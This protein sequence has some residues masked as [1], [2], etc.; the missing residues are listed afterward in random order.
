[1]QE[2]APFGRPP[3]KSSLIADPIEGVGL[4]YG[5]GSK[6]IIPTANLLQYFWTRALDSECSVCGQ[7]FE[8]GDPHIRTVAIDRERPQWIR[9]FDRHLLCLK[10]KE[11]VFIPI[12]HVWHDSVAVAHLQQR[13]DP[14]AA[15][16]L[17]QVLTKILPNVSTSF[18]QLSPQVELWHDYLSIPQWQKDT[19]HAL[20]VMLPEIFRTAPLCLI[21]LDDVPFDVVKAALTQNAPTHV[22]DDYA[23]MST[24]FRARWFERMW[25]S[26][27]YAYC[28][29]AFIYTEDHIIVWDS[30]TE[31]VVS[32]TKLFHA[33]QYKLRTYIDTLGMDK[34]SKAFKGLP[35]PLLGPLADMRRNVW[36]NQG[37]LSFAE[38]LS[39]VAGRKCRSYR[40]RFLT[41]ASFLNIGDY[42]IVLG[43]LPMEPEAACLWLARKCLAKGDYSPLLI[44]RRN[45]TVFPRARWL[46]GHEQM[47]WLNWNLGPAVTLP[48]TSTI[49][50][51]ENRI[52][53]KLDLVG[54][55][56]DFG[57]VSFDQADP[58]DTFDLVVE[59]ILAHVGVN[60]VPGFLDAL[61][62]IYAVPGF[63]QTS[64]FENWPKNFQ[65]R[66]TVQ[67][68]LMMHAMFPLGGAER[69]GIS[70][71]IGRTL[72]FDRR[73]RGTAANF[74][75]MSYAHDPLERAGLYD[76]TIGA[77]RCS[78]CKGT[79]LYRFHILKGA[80]DNVQLYRIDGLEYSSTMPN[81]IGL[82]I[83]DEQIVGRMISGTPACKCKIVK[84]VRIH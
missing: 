9:V 78:G 64:M 50:V 20:L 22:G 17:Y 58:A 82:L 28:R 79:F 15:N 26:L 35:V 37:Q 74:T 63:L 75:R 27:E 19:Q 65:F 59:T 7:G 57:S 24:I 32:F 31:G 4:L 71:Q 48:Q 43:Q 81:G 30:S 73:L 12:S 69:V 29:Q 5:R 21:H 10:R 55:L 80:G 14:V 23:T 47:S 83:S 45:E 33:L 62:P 49:T 51:E 42:S 52:T 46:V 61:T 13:N 39:F 16:C 41:M 8:D 53:L 70:R 68:L 18:V 77:V 72:H 38:A 6:R 34:F 66:N 60:N 2:V 1:M 84:T 3:Q 36:Q 54:T 76:D 11:I 44:L 25:V 67:G 40:D 56:E